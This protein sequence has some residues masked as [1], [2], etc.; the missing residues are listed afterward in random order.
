MEIEQR[1]LVTNPAGVSA[2][3]GAALGWNGDEEARMLQVFQNRKPQQ[4]ASEVIGRALS[5]ES[6]GWSLEDQAIFRECVD[7]EMKMW[8]FT[9]GPEYRET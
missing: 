5:M 6:T 2:A 4:L 1:S 8:G 9:Y 7:E 3:V